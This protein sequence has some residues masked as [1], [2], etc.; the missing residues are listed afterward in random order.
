MSAILGRPHRVLAAGALA[1]AVALASAGCEASR[2]AASS[3]ELCEER[4]IELERGAGPMR[5]E[6]PASR[7]T[8]SCL[9]ADRAADLTLRVRLPAGESGETVLRARPDDPADDLIL[10]AELR[11]G[12]ASSLVRCDDRVTGVTGAEQL[13]LADGLAGVFVHV[14]TRSGRGGPV[15][16]QAFA[17]PAMPPGLPC[18][19]RSA[20]PGCLDDPECDASSRC[21]AGSAC[22]D[23][24]CVRAQA[25]AGEACGGPVSCAPT[26]ACVDGTCGPIL[27]AP[28]DAPPFHCSA[29]IGLVC[30]DGLCADQ[31]A[32]LGERCLR[33]MRVRCTYPLRCAGERGAERCVDDLGTTCEADGVLVVST[34]DAVVPPT[35]GS[36]APGARSRHASACGIGRD[37]PEQVWSFVAPDDR[38]V[39]VRVR[40]TDGGPDPYVYLRGP[41]DCV[42]GAERCAVQGAVVVQS[43][44]G[45]PGGSLFH[46]IVEGPGDYEIEAE[47][48]GLVPSGSPCDPAEPFRACELGARCVEGVCDFDRW[49]PAEDCA[50]STSGVSDTSIAVRVAGHLASGGAGWI[51]VIG[52]GEPAL[53]I[54]PLGLCPPD[55]RVEVREVLSSCLDCGL[56]GV[57]VLAEA[58]IGDGVACGAVEL[59]LPTLRS[60]DLRLRFS[61]EVGGAYDVAVGGPP[62]P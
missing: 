19:P 61:S 58:A 16:V 37:A 11:C 50:C 5:L 21:I 23:G 45:A 42:A 6:V 4:A 46:A 40:A 52:S 35:A 7:T 53:R 54:R 3:E 38:A 51:G 44:E 62:T 43:F 30:V 33:D 60:R 57:P 8:G 34:P 10:V 59:T 9:F 47:T 15:T 55:L 32:G 49:S 29:T 26:L 12:D 14:R 20:E 17:R 24:T 48:V 31:E 41:R 1:A 25:R 18:D 39:R 13:V 36:I 22:V 56:T 2:D 28:C 27:G